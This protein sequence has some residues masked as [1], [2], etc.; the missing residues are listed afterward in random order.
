MSESISSRIPVKGSGAVYYD[1]C[2]APSAGTSWCFGFTI[3]CLG[4][5]LTPFRCNRMIS[6]SFTKSRP[7]YSDVYN[8]LSAIHLPCTIGCKRCEKVRRS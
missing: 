4:N 1:L 6:S 5:T 3:M 2:S 8:Y 7:F